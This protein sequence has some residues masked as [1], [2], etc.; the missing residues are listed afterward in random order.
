M[1]LPPSNLPRYLSTQ[2]RFL[3]GPNF[4]IELFPGSSHHS[5]W[6]INTP[7]ATMLVLIKARF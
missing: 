2:S 4:Q 7:S 5:V 3:L 6:Q 1:L